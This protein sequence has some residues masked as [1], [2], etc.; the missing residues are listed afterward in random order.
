MGLIF[1]TVWR[2]FVPRCAFWHTTVHTTHSLWTYQGPPCV[3][4]DGV[5]FIFTHHERC[6]FCGRHVIASMIIH[7]FHRPGFSNSQQVFTLQYCWTCR[8]PPTSPVLVSETKTMII[9]Y[10]ILVLDDI[11]SND[12]AVKKSESKCLVI[13]CCCAIISVYLCKIFSSLWR[14]CHWQK[15]G[16]MEPFELPWIHPCIFFNHNIFKKI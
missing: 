14:V 4:I 9:A 10:C 6:R 13:K 15:G 11:V 16:S 1:F 5:P 8:K 12:F 2:H 3:P 7:N